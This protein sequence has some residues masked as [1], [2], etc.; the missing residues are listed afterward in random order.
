MKTPIAPRPFTELQRPLKASVI[1]FLPNGEEKSVYVLNEEGLVTKV[2]RELGVHPKQIRV[3]F[4]DT[5]FGMGLAAE[6]FGIV[7]AS[8]ITFTFIVDK[9][10]TKLGVMEVSIAIILRSSSAILT[11]AG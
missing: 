7:E 9:M 5:C 2:A 8:R 4:T 3:S 6:D 10:K 11:S 1:T